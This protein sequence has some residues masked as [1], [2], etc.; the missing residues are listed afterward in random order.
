MEER[1]YAQ[2][3][4]HT[5]AVASLRSVLASQ[6]GV[7]VREDVLRFAGTSVDSPIVTT[8]SDTTGIRRMLEVANRALNS[9]KRWRLRIHTRGRIADLAREVRAGRFPMA[10]VVRWDQGVQILHMVV[11]CGYEPGRVRYF[12]P[13]SGRTRWCGSGAFRKQW[14]DEVNGGITWFAVVSGGTPALG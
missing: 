14:L 11:V 10:S 4:R 3:R 1:F 12:D 13:E 7:H 6:Y 9:G 8:G 2:E 5:C